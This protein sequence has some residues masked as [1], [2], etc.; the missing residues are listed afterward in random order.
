MRISAYHV[1]C[2]CPTLATT[3]FRYLLGEQ[4]C[5]VL[6]FLAES[7]KPRKGQR[8]K[9]F[10]EPPC[11]SSG[12]HTLNT[13][14]THIHTHTH[15][16]IYKHR[17]YIPIHSTHTTHINTYTHILQK[18]YIHTLHTLYNTLHILHTHTCELAHTHA[19]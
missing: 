1:W 8:R 11:M 12:Q 9:P 5:E 19:Y 15:I 18:Q 4:N 6:S 10:M 2:G 3:C 7:E 14:H 13:L 17:P 16:Y